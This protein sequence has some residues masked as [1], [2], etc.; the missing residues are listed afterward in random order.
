MWLT[1]GVGIPSRVPGT[2][3]DTWLFFSVNTESN[4][5]TIST[6]KILLPY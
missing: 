2:P 6:G 3:V 1:F 5:C 4:H